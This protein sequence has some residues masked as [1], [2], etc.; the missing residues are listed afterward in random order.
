[1]VTI[2]D[3]YVINANES[4]FTL[5]RKSK[6]K[7][8]NSKNYGTEIRT[9]EGYYT[10]ITDTLEGYIKAKTRKY[11]ANEQTNSLK[12]LKQEIINLKDFINENFKEEL[13]K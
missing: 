4:C 8:V 7:D 1:M 11:I 12:E 3:E 9:I 6:V 10:S 2:D 5:E 13:I